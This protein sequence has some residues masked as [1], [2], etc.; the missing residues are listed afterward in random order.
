MIDYLRLNFSITYLNFIS[1]HL[2]NR[3]IS[4]FSVKRCS[5]IEVQQALRLNKAVHRS[6]YREHLIFNSFIF[7]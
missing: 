6:L 2:I 1:P 3:K 5:K 7:Y 4:E